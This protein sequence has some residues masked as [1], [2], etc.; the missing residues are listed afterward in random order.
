M[1]QTCQNISLPSVHLPLINRNRELM[2]KHLRRAFFNKRA[3]MRVDFRWLTQQRGS[4]GKQSLIGRNKTLWLKLLNRF[5][6][7]A[8]EKK[9]ERGM[10]IMKQ[11][12]GRHT[13][14]RRGKLN[15]QR[16]KCS[17][18]P[19]WAGEVGWRNNSLKSNSVF[20]M[21]WKHNWMS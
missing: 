13:K 5:E 11:H 17:F 21:T 15:G 16:K 12:G 9:N 1:V 19:R 18:L 20:E 10:H 3:I 4:R 6:R 2:N 7:W 8:G 14:G